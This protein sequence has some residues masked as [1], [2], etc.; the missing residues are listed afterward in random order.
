[1]KS[2]IGTSLLLIATTIPAAATGRAPQRVV[3]GETLTG[4][5]GATE[6][7][8][9]STSLDAGRAYLLEVQQNGLDLIVTAQ[10]PDQKSS[11]FNSPLMRES[12][13]L[14]LLEPEI[15]GSW[16]FRL[17]STEYTGASAAYSI[18]LE[19]L[20]DAAA[21][22]LARRQVL[23]AMTRAARA[24]SKGGTD[25][26]RNSEAAYEEALARARGLRDRALEARAQ[27][28][29]AKLLYEELTDWSRSLDA[30]RAA[31][32]IYRG[33]N[34]EPMYA[35]AIHLE[36]LALIE[37]VNE[38]TKPAGSIQLSN[39]ARA[40]FER[41]RSLFNE[42]GAIRAR[43][44]DQYQQ[45]RVLNDMAVGYY[46][47]GEWGQAGD[48]FE[49]AAQ[50]F[51]AAEEWSEEF[52]PMNNLGNIAYEEG[53]LTDALQAFSRV[54]Q[55]LPSDR[56]AS[57]RGHILDNMGSAYRALGQIDEALASYAQALALHESLDELKGQ[58]RSLSGI[59]VTY[60][61][62]G[63]LE[64]AKQYLE[65][66][67]PMRQ[68]ANDGRG[69]VST[70][71]YLGAIYL[72]QD[73]VGR[74]IELHE[75][76]ATLATSAA[77]QAK[78]QV[79]LGRD[80][81]QAGR[82]DDA[83]QALTL[84]SEL[85]EDEGANSVLADALLERGTLLASTRQFARAR[86]DLLH[87]QSLFDQLGVVGGEARVRYEL[88][89]VARGTGEPA[90]AA[91][92]AR[93]S[94]EFV[95]RQRS[96]ILS[97]ELRAAYLG[98]KRDYYDLYV[99]VLM[100]RQ[101]TAENDRYRRLALETSERSRARAMADLLA[102]A[103]VNFEKDLAPKWRERRE[104]LHRSLAQLRYRH[105]SLLEQGATPTQLAVVLA[106]LNRTETKLD[107]LEVE[108]RTGNPRYAELTA[109]HPL[110]AGA[111]Q[112]M[113]DGNSLLLQFSLGKEQSYLFAV[114]S[115][116]VTAHHLPP[117]SQIEEVARRLHKQL[118][119]YAPGQQARRA[120]DD[121][122]AELANMLLG[123]VAAD[124]ASHSRVIVVG[125]GALNYIPFAILPVPRGGAE[126]RSMLLSHEV[127]SLPSMSVLDSQRA[128]L[129]ARTEPRRT[130]AIFADPVFAL[131]DNRVADV[132]RSAATNPSAA[133]G[134]AGSERHIK[135]PRL[136]ASA[137]EAEAIA[138]L[139]P[140]GQRLVAT[141]L[142]VTRQ[143]VLDPGLSD[144][145][146]L[147]FATHG[148]IDTRYPALS[149]L[150]LS[151][152][153]ADG[154]PQ[155]GLLRLQDIYGLR[156]NADLAVLSA[157]DTALGREVR[158]EGLIG[159]TRGFLYAGA[160][161]VVASLWR[162]PDRATAELMEHFYGRLLQSGKS[163]AAA[164]REAQLDISRER[165]W[166]DPYF[167]AAFV[168]QGDWRPVFAG[169]R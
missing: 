119:I 56:L 147:H 31:A 24:Y 89:R 118:R 60:Y 80:F 113:L 26:W 151:F 18:K 17:H 52:K 95:E 75:R 20:E 14:V 106:D 142:A 8:S 35:S 164:L 9:Y 143:A 25:G 23:R 12:S 41:A 148:L 155:D 102:E 135:L 167:W 144:F 85:A 139:V 97:P 96:E 166:Q 82:L 112:A 71:R 49:R 88:A 21:A 146:M 10:G 83:L 50:M 125:D 16:L 29:L 160:Q 15:T 32:A 70:R 111:M 22:G 126:P 129:Q 117:A 38:I 169:V 132:H 133:G 43:L 124:L 30:A 69:E 5:M 159:L 6:S 140:P 99:D 44:G 136:A 165:R 81:A 2:L 67:L 53:R 37:K 123:S 100:M 163:A 27:L 57:L 121:A 103:A 108:I 154:E 59:G 131:A 19:V 36:A 92:L 66:A 72:Q 62:S 13:E 47:L 157:C 161:T 98:Q 33:L 93:T 107:L 46:Y 54:L 48:Y 4:H 134:L 104:S 130:I 156:F 68:R 79:L 61:T 149:A 84:A 128:A 141:G 150:A 153:D 110:S 162:V 120:L 28:C 168:V 145:R 122:L 109:P 63:D 45:A 40:M 116:T 77:D 87:A 55:L 3:V 65:R 86:T 114:T 152:F 74:A 127:V 11:T 73:D 78:V 115:D 34:D 39:E 58:G 138:K 90:A 64:L 51:R 137:I 158:G 94:I 76:A 7:P 105:E 101:R 91:E 1:M 42:A